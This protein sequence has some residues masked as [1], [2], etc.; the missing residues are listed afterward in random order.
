MVWKGKQIKCKPYREWKGEGWKTVVRLYKLWNIVNKIFL[1]TLSLKKI[2]FQMHR[3]MLVRCKLKCQHNCA[4][5][6]RNCH[7]SWLENADLRGWEWSLLKMQ[8][9]L[10]LSILNFFYLVYG[11]FSRSFFLS[12]VFQILMRQHMAQQGFICRILNPLN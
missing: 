3:Q 11:S 1:T 5:T 6:H 9:E 12:V 10:F 4:S 8:E 7:T 2:F